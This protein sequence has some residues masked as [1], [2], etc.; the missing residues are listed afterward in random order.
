MPIKKYSKV[1]FTLRKE[2]LFILAAIVIMVVA[3]ILLQLPSKE[4]KFNK[5]WNLQDNMLYKEVSIND[6]DNVL[7]D[8]KATD[9]VFVLFVLPKDSATSTH[10]TLI[11]TIAEEFDVKRVYLV[12]ATFATKGDREI[13]DKFN[14][15]LE[16]IENQFTNSDDVT[17][18]LDNVP[19]FWAFQDSK[20]V[21]E[22]NQ[23]KIEAEGDWYS[24]AIEVFSAK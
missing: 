15:K 17:I 16:K 8:K 5:K 22:I 18:T 1:K 20:L 7:E 24:A 9:T 3:T 4:E 13:D 19:N 11:E 10:L 14:E 2:L 23:D 6:L 12:D 21:K